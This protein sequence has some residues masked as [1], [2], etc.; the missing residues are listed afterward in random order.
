MRGADHSVMYAGDTDVFL[1]SASVLSDF[2]E[3]AEHVEKAVEIFFLGV[4]DAKSTIRVNAMSR[5]LGVSINGCHI[6]GHVC[7]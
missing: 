5:K 6:W 7:F 2:V 1:S 3:F 4:L